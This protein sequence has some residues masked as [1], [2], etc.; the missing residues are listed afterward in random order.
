MFLKINLNTNVIYNC[1]YFFS[2]LID[3]PLASP[4][5]SDMFDGQLSFYELDPKSV[6]DARDISIR[7][8]TA[9]LIKAAFL[10]HIRREF[11]SSK[12]L[13]NDLFPQNNDT[14]D[15]DTLLDR[16]ILT[17]ATDLVNDIPASDPR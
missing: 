8:S 7:G 5:Q 10:H 12:M 14:T 3:S 6:V 16:N 17:I 15:V 13:L 4:R 1:L 2:S 9:E 11:Q